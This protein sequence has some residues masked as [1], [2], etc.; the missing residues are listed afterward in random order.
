MFQNYPESYEQE[1]YSG[2]GTALHS[3]ARIG[4]LDMVQALLAEGADPSIKNSMG[5]LAIELAEYYGISEVSACLLT[6]CGSG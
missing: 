1:K 5:Q 3:A 2:L 4:K 6:N